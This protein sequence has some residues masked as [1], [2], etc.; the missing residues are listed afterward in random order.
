MEQAVLVVKIRR[1]LPTLVQIM[2]V[3]LRD[4]PRPF[5]VLAHQPSDRHNISI[6]LQRQARR[7]RRHRRYQA[8]Y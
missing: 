1:R 4:R 5:N 3:A 2:R 6:L 7:A 8:I